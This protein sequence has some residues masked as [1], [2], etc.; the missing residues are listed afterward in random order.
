MYFGS[1]GREGTLY[2]EIIS[3]QSFYIKL[4][5]RCIRITAGLPGELTLWL[6]PL[7]VSKRIGENRSVCVLYESGTYGLILLLLSG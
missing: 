5:F 7:E 4:Y 3:T 2:K 6:D 1:S